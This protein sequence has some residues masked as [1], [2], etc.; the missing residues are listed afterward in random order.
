M[1]H[2]EKENLLLRLDQELMDSIGFCFTGCINRLINVLVGFVDGIKVSISYKE[3]IQ[4]SIQVILKKIH[5]FI[6]QY[7]ISNNLFKT[8]YNMLLQN[9]KISKKYLDKNDK[10]EMNKIYKQM[11]EFVW[12]A[13][14][15]FC[16]IPEDIIKTEHIN[17]NYKMAWID[18]IVELMEN[19]FGKNILT[20]N[21]FEY[22]ILWNN[23]IVITDFFGEQIIKGYWIEESN[24]PF[25][26]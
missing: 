21:N 3:E 2:K 22:E 16:G 5:L 17:E 8:D 14:E 12:E 19:T 26:F 4:M 23:D 15:L 1:N 7:D 13:D 10:I 18:S 20:I 25:M 9:E 24:S 11:S 6:A